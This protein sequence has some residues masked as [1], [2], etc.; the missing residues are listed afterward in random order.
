MRVGDA[1]RQLSAK[2]LEELFARKNDDKLRWDTQICE[3]AQIS[4][5]SETKLKEF[6]EKAGL[7]HTSPENSLMK[8]GLMKNGKFL[9]AAVILFG[10]NPGKF[11]PNAKVRCAVFAGTNAAYAIDMHDFEGDLFYLIDQAEKYIMEHINMGMRLEGLRRIDVPE[12]N[13]DA[14]REAIINAFCHRDYYQY[15]EVHVAIFRDKLEI[16]NPGLLYLGLT[17]KK[18]MKEEVSERRNE[19]IASMFHMVHFIEKWGKGIKLILSKE[20]ETTFKELGNQFYTVFKR[21]EGTPTGDV[22]KTTQKTTAEVL[23]TIQKLSRNYPEKTN[24]IILAVHRK[25]T[26]TINELAELSG[27]S[28]IGVRYTLTKLKKAR[29]IRR[30]GPDKG[31]HWEIT[32]EK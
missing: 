7:K 8:L 23:E 25:P 4:D 10:E 27:L 31:G 16:R 26:I 29:I 18:I 21:K 2:E 30:V 24:K 20:P 13:K 3:K 14:F 22:G 32:E 17:I 12:I 28:K 9:N 5:I 19:L 15:D 1:N 6:L 11:F